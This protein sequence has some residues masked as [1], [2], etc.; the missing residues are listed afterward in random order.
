MANPLPL[1]ELKVITSENFEEVVAPN[2]ENEPRLWLIDKPYGWSSFKCVKWVRKT[3]G[4]KKVGHAGT[5]DPMA[6]GLVVCAEAKATKSI[7]QIQSQFKVYRAEI[8]LGATTP[9][10]DAETEITDT[11]PYNHVSLLMIENVV[12]EK[13][14]GEISQIPPMYSALSKDGVRLYKLARQGLEVERASRTVTVYDFQVH[15]FNEN[16]IDV[17]IKCSKGTYIR[18][19]AYDLAIELG[20]LGY[21]TKLRRTQIGD[22]SVDNAINPEA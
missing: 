3:S 13:F 5:L 7:D 11:K 20:T 4:S 2:S 18:T 14:L 9:S 8:S 16:R 15:S 22:F 6:T 21:L 17:T 19:I 1:H 12:N 10:Q